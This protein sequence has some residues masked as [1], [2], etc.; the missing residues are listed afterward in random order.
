MGCGK[1]K[2]IFN[3]DNNLGKIDSDFVLNF[4]KLKMINLKIN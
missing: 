2:D 4:I 3:D 1:L